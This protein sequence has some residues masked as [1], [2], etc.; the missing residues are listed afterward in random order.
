MTLSASADNRRAS[1]SRQRQWLTRTRGSCVDQP[2]LR[3]VDLPPDRLMDAEPLG[4]IALFVAEQLLAAPDDFIHADRKTADD[5]HRI[6]PEAPNGVDAAFGKAVEAPG[7][8]ANS[9][10]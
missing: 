1:E 6:R 10:G 5:D 9:V 8:A 7:A 3:D 2:P 4:R